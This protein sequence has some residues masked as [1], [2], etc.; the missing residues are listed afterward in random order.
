M[1]NTNTNSIKT[2]KIR[3]IIR[4]VIYNLFKIT[5]LKKD[6]ITGEYVIDMKKMNQYHMKVYNIPIDDNNTLKLNKREYTLLLFRVIEQYIPS[7]SVNNVLYQA[8]IYNNKDFMI[9]NNNHYKSHVNPSECNLDLNIERTLTY[10]SDT[11]TMYILISIQ[12]LTNVYV[13]FRKYLDNLFNDT[14]TVNNYMVLLE[15][16]KSGSFYIK[17]YNY[18]K[19]KASI[20]NNIFTTDN[21]DTIYIFMLFY[22]FMIRQCK[23]NILF[24]NLSVELFD[25]INKKVVA[26]RNKLF[27]QKSYDGNTLTEINAFQYEPYGSNDGISFAEMNIESFYTM[28]SNKMN[29]LKSN[30][31]YK[32]VINI[33]FDTRTATCNI[34]VQKIA[35]S[36]NDEFCTIYSTFWFHCMLNTLSMIYSHD[37]MITS[38]QHLINKSNQTTEMLSTVPIKDWIR[39]IDEEITGLKKTY[40]MKY[41]K[42]KYSI[43]ELIIIRKDMMYEDYNNNK[44]IFHSKKINFKMYCDKLV[45]IFN[46]Y[47]KETDKIDINTFMKYYVEMLSEWKHV[48][49]IDIIINNID[50]LRNNEYFSIFVNYVMYLFEIVHNNNYLTKNEF[51]ILNNFANDK[52]L[53]KT[54]AVMYKYNVFQNNKL[55]GQ[56]LDEHTEY[57][58][59]LKERNDY[60][61][62]IE[63]TDTNLKQSDDKESIGD[64]VGHTVFMQMHKELDDETESFSKSCNE[65]DDCTK[66]NKNLYCD[67]TNMICNHNK[68]EITEEC[69]N[70]DECYSGLCESYKSKHSGKTVK[71]C[72]KKKL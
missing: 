25:K 47:H 53:M 12:D 31:K 10:L 5:T 19:Y 42:K 55:K 21:D 43:K 20:S 22:T 18:T 70:D 44:N 4:N 8:F 9:S 50:K 65:D 72:R 13:E 66:L 30:P 71:Y 6:N 1:D 27:L 15:K 56:E 34:G 11:Y 59:E 52:T 32:D 14:N 26:H 62:T 23:Y 39:M 24:S 49:N 40:K 3:H 61:K 68:K 67:K 45:S 16:N 2:D 33:N 57:Q 38:K 28:L 37:N 41:D 69:N 35:E 58:K 29:S 17:G 36:V 48:N 51:D 63:N 46:K 7:F 54:L 60:L 64:V